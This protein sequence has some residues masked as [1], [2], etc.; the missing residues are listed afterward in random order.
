MTYYHKKYY[1]YYNLKNIN[2]HSEEVNTVIIIIII[3]KTKVQ[4]LKTFQI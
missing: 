2:V 1:S 3:M 4:H